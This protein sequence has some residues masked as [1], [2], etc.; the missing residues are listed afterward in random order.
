MPAR[1]A[2]R[3]LPSVLQA[4]KDLR[5]QPDRYVFLE[6][7]SQDETLRLLWNF[8]GPK[9]L[10]RLWLRSGRHEAMAEIRQILLDRARRMDP[11]NAI[12]LDSDVK[13][14]S[15]DLVEKLT[16]QSQ[17]D[18][19]GGPVQ[20]PA[21]PSFLYNVF[22]PVPGSADARF[23][24]GYPVLLGTKPTHR[25]WPIHEA[26]AVGAG[27]MRISRRLLQDR[28]VNFHPYTPANNVP[29]RTFYQ[30]EDLAYCNLA[31]SFG[32]RIAVDLSLCL[33]HRPSYLTKTTTKLG[34]H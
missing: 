10:I 13:P 16:A 6:N 31:L 24:L 29:G 32:Y 30:F 15:K 8:P 17:F 4:M 22:V 12:F 14:I 33:T 25:Q 20:I 21:D 7:N 19:L 2:D 27:C 1:D 9:E 26:L 18:V 5:P 11:E 3:T 23:P 34:T 28:R